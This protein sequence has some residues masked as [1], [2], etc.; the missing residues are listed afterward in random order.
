MDYDIAPW[1]FLEIC[2]FNGQPHSESKFN[3]K[4]FPIINS[5]WLDGDLSGKEDNS[6]LIQSSDDWKDPLDLGFDFED[7]DMYPDSDLRFITDNEDQDFSVDDQH[8]DT[9][10]RNLPSRGLQSHYIYKEQDNRAL[11]ANKEIDGVPPKFSKFT[12][13]YDKLNDCRPAKLLN[14]YHGNKIYNSKFSYQPS[15]DELKYAL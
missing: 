2:T 4:H 8:V 13:I 15:S 11:T 9:L 6:L 12:G 14:K 10:V 5:S 1:N 3:T 7:G